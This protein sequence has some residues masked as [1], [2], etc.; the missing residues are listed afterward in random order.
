ME[1]KY[2]VQPIMMWTPKSRPAANE[3]LAEAARQREMIR[4][5]MA[6]EE[7]QRAEKEQL[8]KLLKKYG[9]R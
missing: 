1:S 6:L 4:Q 9:N 8:E 7:Q 2:N 5:Q 3:E